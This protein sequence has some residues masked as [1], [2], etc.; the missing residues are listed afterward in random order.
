MKYLGFFFQVQTESLGYEDDASMEQAMEKAFH[1]QADSIAAFLRTV[2]PMMLRQLHRNLKNTALN[3]KRDR[4][5][6]PYII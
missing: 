1:E 4:Q 2:S 6:Q 5:F 3:S